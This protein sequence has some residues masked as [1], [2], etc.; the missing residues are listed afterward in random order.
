M[1]LQ[2]GFEMYIYLIKPPYSELYKFKSTCAYNELGKYV[3]VLAEIQPSLVE[4]YEND[5]YLLQVW[6]QHGTKVFEKSL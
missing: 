5:K 6:D 2:S 1:H 4:F 3:P